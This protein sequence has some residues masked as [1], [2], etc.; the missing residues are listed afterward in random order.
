VFKSK[1]SGFSVSG[2]ELQIQ[3]VELWYKVKGL[4]LL[5]FRV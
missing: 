1:E 5:G 2:V 3:G 4:G